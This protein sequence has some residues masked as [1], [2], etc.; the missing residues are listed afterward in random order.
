MFLL[1]LGHRFRVVVVILSSQLVSFAQ[2]QT[3][4][5]VFT[6]VSHGHSVPLPSHGHPSLC[7]RYIFLFVFLKSLLLFYGHVFGGVPVNA[8]TFLSSIQC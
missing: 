3:T 1:G 7:L 4:P 5:S 8:L 6:S 2:V